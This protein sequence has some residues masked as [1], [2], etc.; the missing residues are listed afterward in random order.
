MCV[1]FFWERPKSAMHN[2]ISCIAVLFVKYVYT[3][4][5]QM[6]RVTYRNQAASCLDTLDKKN[7][8]FFGRHEGMETCRI[9]WNTVWTSMERYGADVFGSDYGPLTCWLENFNEILDWKKSGN[10]CRFW[11]YITFSI[12]RLLNRI[13]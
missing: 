1:Q 9:F 12:K 11:A 13:N 3:R 10:F 7:A 5:L 8:S 4:N 6:C 2:L